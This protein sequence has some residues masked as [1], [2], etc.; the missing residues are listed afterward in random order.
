[1]SVEHVFLAAVDP[2]LLKK[3]VRCWNSFLEGSASKA[4]DL[5]HSFTG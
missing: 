5:L 4:N 2:V 1:M 3:G